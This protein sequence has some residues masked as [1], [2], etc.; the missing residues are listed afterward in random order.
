VI[1]IEQNSDFGDIDQCLVELE[2]VDQADLELPL[3]FAED[4][5]GFRA[6]II[7][8]IITWA[9]HKSGSHVV[10]CFTKTDQRA[11]WLKSLCASQHG[12][13]AL[14]MAPRVESPE[15][16]GLE[17]KSLDE[18]HRAY[19]QISIKPRETVDGSFFL[20]T[21]LFGKVEHAYDHLSPKTA[22]PAKI[23]WFKQEVKG[24]LERCVSG[25]GAKHLASDDS[26][27]IAEIAYELFANAEEW[28][29]KEIDDSDIR[30]NVRGI[31]LK[32]HKNPL[33]GFSQYDETPTT[34]YLDQ[35]QAEQSAIP[36]LLEVSIFDAGVGLA[37]HALA[38]RITAT[39]SLKQEYENVMQCLRKYSSA[40]GR[41]YRGLGLHYVM[42][43]LTQTKGFLRYRSG[44]LSLFRNFHKQPFFPD[45]GRDALDPT[46][47]SRLRA[48]NVYFFD[49]RS[50]SLDL[51]HAPP[52][53][54]ALFTLLF[55]LKR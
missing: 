45:I 7:Q 16:I 29:S 41:T 53:D 11:N 37:Q 30:P 24:Q 9:R 17:P 54:G 15:G 46:R 19:E 50:R 2:R 20:V 13:V 36:K 35:W 31:I 22:P 38:K 40:S 8:A 52:V 27:N 32:V 3:R 18:A 12:L 39:T 5:I 4:R 49:W 51:V 21:N 10:P 42:S 44:R 47:R 55:P 34:E 33:R 25:S 1:S 43:L 26:S 23:E 14:L 48:K 28:G 6:A